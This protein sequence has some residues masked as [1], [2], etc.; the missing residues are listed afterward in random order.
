MGRL[1]LLLDGRAYDR[2]LARTCLANE[3]RNS[4][5]ASPARTG[6]WRGPLDESPWPQEIGDWASNR[7]G[8][9]EGRRIGSY[10]ALHHP[11][12]TQREVSV[13]LRMLPASQTLDARAA[14]LIRAKA[15]RLLRLLRLVILTGSHHRSKYIDSLPGQWAAGLGPIDER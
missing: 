2:C 15:R 8:A 14:S 9:R 12:K 3:E 4:L 5:P 6:D 1:R 13:Q 7:K 11:A 10:I